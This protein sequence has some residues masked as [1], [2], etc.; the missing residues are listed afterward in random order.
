MFKFKFGEILCMMDVIEI[1]R[2]NNII[3]CKK[4]G[5]NFLRKISFSSDL[6]EKFEIFFEKSSHFSF[7]R[8]L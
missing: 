1:K 2:E 8:A 5:L 6:E 7:L 3:A 4:L